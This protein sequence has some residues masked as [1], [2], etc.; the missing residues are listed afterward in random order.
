[1]TV[2]KIYWDSATFLAWFQED[3][4]QFELCQ[5]TLDKAKNGEVIIVT[6]SL[7]IAE[8]LWL[9]GQQ[10]IPK[11]KAEIVQK[12][13]RRSYI[14]VVNVTRK[15][16][17]EAQDLVWDNDIN[18]K[19]A[20]HVATAISLDVT[21]FETFDKKL[22]NKAGNIGTKNLIFRKPIAPIQGKLL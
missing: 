17:H 11:N 10:K 15:L 14:R 18:P 12:F 9:R 21:A 1:M 22:L 6:S 16:A 3:Q 8:V 4:G 2:E 20:I 13:F 5:S 7:A 19:D